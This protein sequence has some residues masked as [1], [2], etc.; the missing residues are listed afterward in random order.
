MF[1]T[2]FPG[3]RSRHL[4]RN[5]PKKRW[6][7][8]YAYP[9]V[10]GAYNR[11]TAGQ[12]L[13]PYW[14]IPVGPLMTA[15]RLVADPG[16]ALGKPPQTRIVGLPNG[17]P[18][19]IL[20]AALF[21]GAYLSSAGILVRNLGRFP[22]WSLLL[23]TGVVAAIGGATAFLFAEEGRPSDEEAETPL[24]APQGR[25][26]EP[27]TR[28]LG[29]P[30]PEVGSQQSVDEPW[31]ET[32][33]DD[34]LSGSARSARPALTPGRTRPDLAP[35]E[36]EV[37]LPSRASPPAPPARAPFNPASDEALAEIEAILLSLESPTPSAPP[38]VRARPESARSKLEDIGPELDAIEREIAPRRQ[39]TK[40][41]PR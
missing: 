41:A 12:R 28:E 35:T 21:V 9:F 16:V 3:F 4:S 29:R 40:P 27:G 36:P 10:F 39:R 18:L 2:L 5:Y 38:A 32:W 23:L 20:A 6:L 7:R 26:M 31:R 1:T 34:D 25:E 11:L 30:R 17:L 19:F 24:A 33:P 8:I 13:S 22:L 14:P 37:V 15:W